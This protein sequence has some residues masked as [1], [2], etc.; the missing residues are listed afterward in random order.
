M[1]A[2]SQHHNCILGGQEE[3]EK[4]AKDPPAKS[5]CLLKSLPE[6]Q[7]RNVAGLKYVTWRNP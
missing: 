7:L 2:P 3:K 5:L 1:S 4:R 6:A